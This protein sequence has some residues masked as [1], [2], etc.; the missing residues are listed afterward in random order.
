VE[1]QQN[2]PCGIAGT[3][4]QEKHGAEP[5]LKIRHVLLGIWLS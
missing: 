2:G 4:V 3:E 5:R 1:P